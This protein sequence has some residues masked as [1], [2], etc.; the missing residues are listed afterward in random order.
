[1]TIGIAGIG[2]MGAPIAQRLME[3][4]HEV[5]VWNR[6]A[7][8]TK[9]LTDAG[10]TVAATPSILAAMS[11]TVITVLTDAAAIEG[12]YAGPSGLLS[13]EVGGKLFI[14]MS[15]VPP[16]AQAALA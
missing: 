8:K 7:A 12:V 13:G 3:V 15:T 1:M 5:A 10:A 16:A 4:G 11:E 6:T 9:P 14:E 2:L